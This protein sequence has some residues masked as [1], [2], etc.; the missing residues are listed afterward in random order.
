M[1]YK[2]EAKC[3]IAIIKDEMSL[4]AK[5]HGFGV[6]KEYRFGTNDG[7]IVNCIHFNERGWII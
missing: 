3:E 6:L 1:I 7:D 2:H 5:E 4:K